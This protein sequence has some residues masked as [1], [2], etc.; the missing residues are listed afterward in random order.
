MRCVRLGGSRASS[1]LPRVACRRT[2]AYAIVPAASATAS[3]R[4]GF[5]RGL[6][7]RRKHLRPARVSLPQDAAPDLPDSDGLLGDVGSFKVDS[8]G[9]E[10]S[11]EALLEDKASLPEPEESHLSFE[12][13]PRNQWRWQTLARIF[14]FAGPALVIPLADPIMSFVDTLCVGRYASTMELA[15]LGPNTA[16]FNFCNFAFASLGVSTMSVV[17]SSIGKGNREEAG[18]AVA[19][20]I[21]IALGCGLVI[22]TGMLTFGT[23]VVSRM[24]ADQSLVPSAV[25]YLK[26]RAMAAPATLAVMVANSGMLAQ[27]DSVTPCTV[28]LGGALLNCA[29]DFV[30]IAG[31]GM[32]LRGAA[33]ATAIAQNFCAAALIFV[34][35]RGLNGLIKVPF[36]FPKAN[37]MGPFFGLMGPLSVVYL[38]KEFVWLTVLTT[39]TRLSTVAL[40]AHQMV[41]ALFEPLSF[42]F[43][44]VEQ[45]AVAFLPSAMARSPAEARETIALLVGSGVSLALILSC[46]C[47]LPAIVPGLFT[48]DARLYAGMRS[49]WPIAVSSLI[50]NG[51]DVSINGVILARQELWVIVSRI[52]V[53]MAIVGVYYFRLRSSGAL[54]LTGVWSGVL[55]FFSCRAAFNVLHLVRPPPT[56]LAALQGHAHFVRRFLTLRTSI[57]DTSYFDYVDF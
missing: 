18:R 5:G 34:H 8:L 16:I 19:H 35:A 33:L 37:Q 32:G 38:G 22:G 56:S 2:P 43:I 21:F 24:V 12:I 30:L 11:P 46:I 26:T 57:S 20:G 51:V 6:R 10:L 27:R 42:A 39:A 31:L 3:A 54:T 52:M 45:A 7:P 53:A 14:A 23:G 55:L 4:G 29:L 15:A 41:W 36:S 13:L 1:V 49:L 47:V 40:A 17:A 28:V 25:A 9:V 50:L 44:P 48:P